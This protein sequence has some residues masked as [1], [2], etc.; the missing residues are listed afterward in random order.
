MRHPIQHLYVCA[1]TSRVY[2]GTSNVLHVFAGGSG[3]LIASWTA[4]PGNVTT[5]ITTAA[6]DD[7]EPENKCGIE[8]DG[9]GKEE[10]KKKNKKKEGG[11]K[12]SL[13]AIIKILTVKGG[14]FV[15]VATNDDKAVTV[16]RADGLE[17]LSVRLVFAPP[18]SEG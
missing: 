18:A 11:E 16:L 4:A 10:K 7:E 8:G 14:E 15:L 13:N 5:A 1:A 12:P 6:A 9:Q 3:E 2:T 17:V